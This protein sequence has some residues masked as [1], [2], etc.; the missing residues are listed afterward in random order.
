MISSAALGG[1]TASPAGSWGQGRFVPRQAPRL[2]AAIAMVVALHLAA[3]AFRLGV[4]G[5]S[6]PASAAPVMAVRVVAVSR[7]PA[8]PTVAPPRKPR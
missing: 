5:A 1:T 4:S 3:L 7:A 2:S 6:Q 8:P